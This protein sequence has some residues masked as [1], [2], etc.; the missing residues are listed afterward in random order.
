MHKIRNFHKVHSTVGEW[1]GS[2]KVVAG[3]QHGMC[4]SALKLPTF[5]R[6]SIPPSWEHSKNREVSLDVQV[7]QEGLKLIGT[8]QL[9]VYADDINTLGT[10]VHTL[11]KNIQAFVAA[12]QEIG[13]EVKL[14]KT[15]YMVMHQDQNA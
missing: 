11:K 15:E 14:E 13:L 9:L 10:S 7:N 8:Y 3:E 2:G 1:Q 6:K 4:K 12:R 5:C